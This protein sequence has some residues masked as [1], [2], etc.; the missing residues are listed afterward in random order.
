MYDMCRSGRPTTVESVC[1]TS[2]AVAATDSQ[3]ISVVN[4]FDDAVYIAVIP[5]EITYKTFSAI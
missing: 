1:G 2:T 5:V 4:W 3:T